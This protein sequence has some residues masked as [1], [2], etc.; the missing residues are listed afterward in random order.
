MAASIEVTCPKC[1]NKSRAP[2]TMQGKN[3][4]CKLCQVVFVVKGPG[5]SIGDAEEEGIA[6]NPYGVTHEDLAPRCPHCAYSMDPPDA[7]ICLHCGY[8]MQKR[9]RV[10]S[11]KVYETTAGDVFA[12]HIP[13][14]ACL[15]GI[16]VLL[17]IDVLALIFRYPI[18]QGSWFDNGDGT[19]VIKPGI[20]PLYIFLASLL[21]IV[22]CARFVIK[23]LIRFVPPEVEKKDKGPLLG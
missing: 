13:T 11:K 10:E 7:R 20:I 9:R 1:G 8:D 12:Y 6:T 2:A 15:I 14:V 4:R 16:A 22:P 21:G 5:G 18:M 3:A 19:W 17:T 23:R